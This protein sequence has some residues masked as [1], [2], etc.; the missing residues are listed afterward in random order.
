MADIRDDDT[1]DL[2]GAE[3]PDADIGPLP[4]TVKHY[5]VIREIGAGGM[6]RVLKCL[7]TTLN[8]YVA[9]KML[10]YG[11]TRDGGFIERFRR[12]ALAVAKTRHPNI[13]Q[14]HSIGE[15]E[16]RVFYSMEYVEGE[17]LDRLLERRGRFEE[18]EA[19]DII[20]QTAEG[21]AHVHRAGILHRDVKT[22]NILLDSSKRVVL[23][24]FGLAKMDYQ[25]ILKASPSTPRREGD[26]RS[27][28]ETDPGR[29]MGTPYYMAPECISGRTPDVRSDIYSLGIVF[30]EILTNRVPFDGDSP[31]EIFHA[32]LNDIPVPVGELSPDTSLNVA[33]IVYKCIEKNPAA[34]YQNCQ[35][36]LQ[37]LNKVV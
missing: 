26:K 13:V 14:I 20:R 5:K 2:T 36:L 11:L 15:D 24:D 25:Q 12:E 17:G 33:N 35:E 21:L 22:N 7:D 9:I 19:V 1:K 6:G 32:H 30:Y 27:L 31:S 29:V 3:L 28:G 16:G 34:R 10:R 8:R 4:D 23:T 37:D 18:A